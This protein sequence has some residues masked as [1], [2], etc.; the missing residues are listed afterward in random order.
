VGTAFYELKKKIVFAIR[1]VVEGTIVC[2]SRVGNKH[3]YA[4]TDFP[5]VAS[6]ESRWK[7]IR[8]E[9]DHVLQYKS[10]IPNFQDISKEQIALTQ[11]DR[12]K[13]YIFNIYGRKVEANCNAC[14]VTARVLNT[15]PGLRTAFYSIL[16]PGKHLAEHRGPYN[17]VLRYHLALK[18]PQPA[19]ACALVVGGEMA[20][21]EEGKSLIFDDSFPH[22]AWNRSDEIRVVLFVDF[23]RPLYFP[24]SLINDFVLFLVP[25]TSFITETVKRQKLWNKDPRNAIPKHPDPHS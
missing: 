10:A 8:A 16:M 15:I 11:D 9:L 2:F 7:E 25:Y 14:P 21:W 20:H 19:F 18:V 13:T 3:L 4:S 1:G 22:E 6:V 5:W 12:W 24:V 17:G 23:K